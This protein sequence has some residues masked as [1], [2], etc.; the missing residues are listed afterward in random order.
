MKFSA[1]SRLT[2]RLSDIVPRLGDLSIPKSLPSP[3]TNR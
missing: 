2:Q 3:A 1:T